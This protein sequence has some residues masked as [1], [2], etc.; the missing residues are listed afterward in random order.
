MLQ[1]TYVVVYD[2][3]GAS[4]LYARQARR[5]RKHDWTED[6][7]QARKFRTRKAARD[8]GRRNSHPVNH[9]SIHVLSDA[10]LVAFVLTRQP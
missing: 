1:E 2:G 5:G 3:G 8:V 10:Q 4:I 6:L 7:A 9:P